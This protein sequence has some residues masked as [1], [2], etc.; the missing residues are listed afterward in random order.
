M[1]KPEN[2]AIALL[3]ARRNNGLSDWGIKAWE[4]RV[5]A[6]LCSRGIDRLAA[7][8]TPENVTARDAALRCAEPVAW[9]TKWPHRGDVWIYYEEKPRHPEGPLEP[10]YNTLPAEQPGAAEQMREAAVNAL[11][12][13]LDSLRIMCDRAGYTREGSD[14]SH[15]AS[16][17]Q[18]ARELVRALPLPTPLDSGTKGT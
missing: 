1:S 16:A 15:R 18:E 3:I 14:L 7:A 17:M 11:G 8:P 4:E 10:L 5:D 12:E 6:Y 9:R 13:R 2:T